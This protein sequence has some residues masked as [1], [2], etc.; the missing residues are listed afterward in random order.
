M[1]VRSSWLGFARTMTSFWLTNRDN[2]GAV[3][4][5]AKGRIYRP[6]CPPTMMYFP[7]GIKT[8]LHAN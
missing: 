1:K 7:L 4:A 5:R 8:R 2:A 6:P 3:I